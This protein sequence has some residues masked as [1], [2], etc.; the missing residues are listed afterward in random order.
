MADQLSGLTFWRLFHSLIRHGNGKAE[1]DRAKEVYEWLID[2]FTQIRKCCVDYELDLIGIIGDLSRDSSLLPTYDIVRDR[3]VATENSEGMLEALKE[4]DQ[5][6]ETQLTVNHTPELEVILKEHTENF[7]R[8]ALS[9]VLDKAK[10]IAN[11][12]VEDKKRKLSGAKDAMNY[13][14]EQMENGILVRADKSGLNRPIDV[15]TEAEE[16]TGDY[17][18]L[19]DQGFFETGFP[20]IR[21]RPSNF[22]GILGHAGQGKSTVGRFMLYTMAAAGKNVCEITLENDAEVERNKFIL[23]HAHNP[24]FNG[25]FASL[26][27]EKFINGRLTAQERGFLAEVGKDFKKN[28]GGRIKIRQPHEASD[29]AC[30]NAIESF[31]RN[32]PL[33]AAM[34]DYVQLIEPDA[35]NSDERKT[36][37]STMIKDWR[38]YALN[39]DGTRKLVLLTPIQGNEDGFKYA[40]DHDG[41]WPKSASGINTD[42]ELARS[43]DVIVGIFQKEQ[44]PDKESGGQNHIVTFSNVKDRDKPEF[45]PFLATMTGCGWFNVGGMVAS[46]TVSLPEM[47]MNDVIG[48]DISQTL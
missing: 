43:C 23:I 4:Y 11:G 17:D 19:L 41:E 40:Q 13:I 28:V 18:R 44:V 27:Y 32:T 33:D 21:L 24:Y 38:Q 31:H 1:N 35:R 14:M 5:I 37:M 22:V 46:S 10:R 30:K 25:E 39:F 9:F 42:K 29:I 34:V 47:T 16:I 2:N 48:D 45:A 6:S 7:E 26:T 8:G 15:Q 3:V 36:K 20:L 12:K